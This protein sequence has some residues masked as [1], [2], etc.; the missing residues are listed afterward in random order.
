MSQP[1]PKETLEYE[2]FVDGL[3]QENAKMLKALRL[4]ESR[5]ASFYRIQFA[6]GVS[7][8]ADGPE[9]WVLKIIR[10]A[11]PAS[12]EPGEQAEFP[13]KTITI[14]IEG[15][16]VQDVT[17]I[18]TGCEVRVEDYDH[19]DDT[20]PTWDAKKECHVTVYEGDGV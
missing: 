8:I 14:H 2:E 10:D 4:A 9:D 20:Q 7:K 18:P 6:Q 12:G 15:G 1:I 13:A 5:L 11:L 16:L 17:G 3:R 19:P